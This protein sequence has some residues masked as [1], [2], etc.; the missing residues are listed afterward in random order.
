MS[1]AKEREARI[2]RK[3]QCGRGMSG[4]CFVETF[5]GRL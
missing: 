5:A 4:S 3:A 1:N 2:E